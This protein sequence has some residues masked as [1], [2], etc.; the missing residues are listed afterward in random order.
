[1]R[2]RYRVI[3]ILLLAACLLLAGCGVS[4]P[5]NNS[6]P[7][8][9]IAAQNVDEIKILRDLT[10]EDKNVID[11]PTEDNLVTEVGGDADILWPNDLKVLFKESK[12]IVK[13][14]V[15]QVEYTHYEGN[16]WIKTD[17][18]VT[19]AYKGGL[20]EGDLISIYV[21]GGYIPL[22]EH[23]RY[24]D[25][26]FRFSDMTKSEINKTVFKETLFD[27]PF[28]EVGEESIYGL[29]NNPEYS[30]LPKE[31][32]QRI[33]PFAQLTRNS[34]GL[35]VQRATDEMSAGQSAYSMDQLAD[36]MK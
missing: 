1:M 30:V 6:D 19:E 2:N 15:K 25:N 13:G 8:N 36:M 18:A 35:Y 16:A 24:F 29:V 9:T 27:E 31:G 34:D 23:I 20:K 14:V 5:A 28:P 26:A 10:V 12:Y 4:T 21:I 33:L 22:T 32:Y 3:L 17:V 11:P 7:T